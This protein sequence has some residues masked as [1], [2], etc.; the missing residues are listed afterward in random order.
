MTETLST[1]GLGTADLGRPQYINIRQEK[2]KV[3]TLEEFR[4]S[5]R[6]T[7]EY[8]YQ[9]GIRYFDTAPGYGLAEELLLDW[10]KVKNDPNIE[11]ATK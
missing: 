10:V 6:D 7:L 2:N 5:S 4:K 8:A 11:V 1:I 9:Q 3:I